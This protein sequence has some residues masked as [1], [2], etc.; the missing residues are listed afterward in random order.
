MP[1][2]ETKLLYVCVIGVPNAGKS[3]LVNSMIGTKVSI[4]T[5]KIHTTRVKMKGILT[6][7]QNQI[8]FLDTPGIFKTSKIKEK[9]MVE[10]AFSALD[11]ADAILLLIDSKKGFSDD[12]EYIIQHLANYYESRKINK[13]CDAYINPPKLIFAFNKIDVIKKKQLLFL[14]TELEFYK[15]KSK[16]SSEEMLFDK[17][18]MISALKESGI[19]DMKNYLVSLCYP[20][21][22]MY[23]AG[24]K[25][26]VPFA[27]FA[28]ELVREKIM[29]FNHKEIPYKIDVQTEK[30]ENTQNAKAV[31][32]HQKIIVQT[33]GHKKII[34]GKNGEGLKRI[35]ILARKE[36][37]EIYHKKVNLFLFIK[38]ATAKNLQTQ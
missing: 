31:N 33:N 11:D 36:L 8:V 35:G 13:N 27:K 28:E 15:R 29:I 23:D 18:F 26:D 24:Q 6:E 7:G 30:L 1:D 5:P 21:P 22:F 10:E 16:E 19:M 3:S 17:V 4:V 38:V 14:A 34:I 9:P 32:I 37:E 12:I 25:T 2:G 20:S